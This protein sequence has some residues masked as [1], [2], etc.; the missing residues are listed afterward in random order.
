MS[1]AP[2]DGL[3]ADV[4]G[5]RIPEVAIGRFPVRTTADVEALVEKTLQY[6]TLFARK[7]LLLAAD[8]YDAPTHFSFSQASEELT[9]S[10]PPDWQIDRAYLDAMT[11]ADA[12]VELLSGLN[13]GVAV[14]SYMGHSGPI[15]WTF[16]GL[17]SNTDAAG[18]VNTVCRPS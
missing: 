18:L 14:T 8:G 1:Y 4:D 13:A 3:L 9:A 2:A 6:E 17:F 16:D 5:D 10:V 15:V 7:S 12:R 11:V